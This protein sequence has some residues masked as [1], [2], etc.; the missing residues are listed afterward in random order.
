MIGE[1]REIKC[2]KCKKCGMRTRD[3]IVQKGKKV[4]WY[5]KCSCGKINRI[6]WEVL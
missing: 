1:L 3:K 5:C 2:Q 4:Y 6:L